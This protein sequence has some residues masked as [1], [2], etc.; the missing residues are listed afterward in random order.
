MKRNLKQSKEYTI[1]IAKLFVFWAFLGIIS[2]YHG[3]YFLIVSIIFSS[4]IILSTIR[5]FYWKKR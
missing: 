2:N 5:E 4:V 1:R 3:T